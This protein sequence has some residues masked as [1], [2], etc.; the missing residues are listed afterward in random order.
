[1]GETKPAKRD[2]SF[3]KFIGIMGFLGS[4]VG[5]GLGWWVLGPIGAII[6]MFLGGRAESMTSEAAT[7]SSDRGSARDGFVVSLL[8]LMAAVMK[9]DGKVL[10]SELDYV[11]NYLVNM[12]GVDQAGE[13]LKVLRDIMKKEIP[14][15][16]V[17]HQ[18]RVNVNYDSR[19]QLLHLLFGVA[20]ADG[21][22]NTVEVNEIQRISD[23]LGVSP[24]DYQS[25]LN[26]FYSNREAPYRVLEIA[27]S[28]TDQEVKKAYR[29]MAL[30]FHP[31]KVA[32]L[33]PEFQKSA[34]AKF[35]KVNEAYD[36]IKKERGLN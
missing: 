7:A 9:S 15:S 24:A 20:M 13:A 8:V 26:M 21:V 14:L 2:A 31:D 19:V 32:H 28:A 18:I 34:H 36:L 17:C 16:D 6:G 10:R 11:K 33:G 1:L 27:P 25:V 30:R 12:L 35:S 29:N 23:G 3:L 4:L 22:L 5:F